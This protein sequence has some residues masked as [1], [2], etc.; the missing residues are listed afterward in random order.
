MAHKIALQ[1]IMYTVRHVYSTSCIQYV[2]YTVRHVYSTSCIQ[3]VMY[4]VRHVY[5]TSCKQYVLLVAQYWRWGRE[6]CLA[7]ASE[8]R[9]HVTLHFPAC[10]KH[11]I[12]SNKQWELMT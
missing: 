9:A 6:S 7:L 10:I 12:A 5:S 8:P 1:F 3:Y 2:M 11:A 4:T